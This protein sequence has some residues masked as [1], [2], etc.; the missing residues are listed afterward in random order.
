MTHLRPRRTPAVEAQGP[1]QSCRQ[2]RRT[3]LRRTFCPHPQPEIY[4]STL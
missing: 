1:A 3:S 2:S 4:P